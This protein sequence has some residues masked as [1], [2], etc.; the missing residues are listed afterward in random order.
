MNERRDK[1]SSIH[2]V[3]RFNLFCEFSSKPEKIDRN[4][5]PDPVEDYFCISLFD[6]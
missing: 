3:Y 6:E 4:Y 1:S 2:P 5:T